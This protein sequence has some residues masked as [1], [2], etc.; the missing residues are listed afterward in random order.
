MPPDA[1]PPANIALDHLQERGAVEHIERVV[2]DTINANV[3]N[4]GI[5]I[6]KVRLVDRPVAA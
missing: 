2:D 4:D 1:M 6:V 5:P 3:D